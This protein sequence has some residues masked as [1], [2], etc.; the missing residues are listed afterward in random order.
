MRLI[1]RAAARIAK[2][3]RVVARCLSNSTAGLLVTYRWCL[4]VGI[5]CSPIQTPAAFANGQEVVVQPVFVNGAVDPLWTGGIRHFDQANGFAYECTD[6]ADA[7]CASLSWGLVM[8]DARGQVLQIDW[9]ENHP[10][11]GLFFKSFEGNDFSDFL[12]GYVSFD[13]RSTTGPTTLIMKVDC[14]YPCTSGEIRVAETVTDV[15]QQIDVPVSTLEDQET[16]FDISNVDTGLVIWPEGTAHTVLQLDNVRWRMPAVQATLVVTADPASIDVGETSKLSTSGGSGNGDV[17]YAVAAE[18]PCSVSGSTLTGTG[19]GTCSVTATKAG[20]STYAA[21]TSAVLEVTVN[22]LTGPHNDSPLFYDDFDL[23]WSDEFSGTQLDERYWNHNIG[24]G[25]GGWGN[26]EWQYYR[27][28]NASVANGFLTITAKEE[29]Y[30]GQDYTSSRIKT[31]GLVDFTYGRVDIRAKLPRG[32]G[33]WPALWA[34]G[35]NFGEV[36][37]PYSG[38][39]DIMEMIGGSGREDT[40]HG[41]VHWNVGGLNSGYQ[42]AMVGGHYT[43]NDFSADFN[44]FSIIRT[45]TQITWHVNNIPYFQFTIDDSPDRAP[46]RKPFFFIFNIAVGGDWPGY[47]NETTVFPQKMLVDYVRIFE[48]KDGTPP[49]DTDEDGLSDAVEIALGTSPANSDT[50]ADGLEDGAEYTL[51]TDPLNQDSDDDGLSDGNEVSIG[52]DPLLTD[53]DGDGVSDG[54][55]ISGGTDPLDDEEEIPH[56][57]FILILYEASKRAKAAQ[58]P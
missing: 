5:I 29:N 39:I 23:A 33:I 44:V 34:L 55:E 56:S 15:W 13:I 35:S 19:A 58:S 40:V 25:S 6:S 49:P 57:N 10:L 46:F 20:D 53:T 48:P 2:L 24:T 8:D 3:L 18:D 22:P 30:G 32:Q 38:E 21:A 26:N 36:G 52:T 11:A 17:T 4:L 41:T 42:R 28:Q 1:L 16:G 54:D 50:D 7:G 43:A 37:W 9:V 51:G 45:A 27:S 12:E 31:E 47:P 14:G